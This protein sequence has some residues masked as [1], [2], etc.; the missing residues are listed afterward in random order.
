MQKSPI[1]WT[2]YTSNPIY[3]INIETGKRGHHCVH[4][5]ELCIHCYAESINLRWGTGLEFIAQNDDKVRFGLSVKELEAL[6]ALDIRLQKKGERANVFVG[7][8]TDIFQKKIPRAFLMEMF[9]YFR[10][11]R[12]LTLQLLTKRAVE[13]LEFIDAYRKHLDMTEQ[14]FKQDFQHVHMGISVGTQKTYDKDIWKLL[15]APFDVLWLSIEPLLGPIDLALDCIEKS[16]QSPFYFHNRKAIHPCGFECGGHDISGSVGWIVVGGESGSGARP[17]HPDWIRAL[18]FQCLAAGVPFFFKQ[19]G[20]FRP[21][22]RPITSGVLVQLNGEHRKVI[23]HKLAERQQAED[24][25]AALMSHFSSK[26]MAG[27]ELDGRTWDELPVV[28]QV[29]QD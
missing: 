29:A 24:V 17:L 2:D 14:E 27:R 25:G 6:R 5:N 3:A 18:R 19:W 15:R 26:K 1:E 16:D 21:A 10:M 8:M 13:M 23:F 9:D 28:A 12:A 7:D 11:F 22:S 20:N 4:A